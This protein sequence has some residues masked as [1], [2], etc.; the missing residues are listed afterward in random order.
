MGGAAFSSFCLLFLVASGNANPVCDFTVPHDPKWVSAAIIL[1]DA[2]VDYIPSVGPWAEAFVDIMAL[3]Q[4]EEYSI[5][6]AACV[7]TLIEQQLED[8]VKKSTGML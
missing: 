2:I 3:T 1:A 4:E 7:E 8:E 5:D 6:V